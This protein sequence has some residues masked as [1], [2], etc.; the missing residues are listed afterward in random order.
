MMQECKERRSSENEEME[1]NHNKMLDKEMNMDE[2][3][4]EA[5]RNF[6]DIVKLNEDKNNLMRAKKLMR[7]KIKTVLCT[8]TMKLPYYCIFWL[9]TFIVT[10]ITESPKPKHSL[11]QKVT[12][13]MK[14]ILTIKK[15]ATTTNLV[16]K[17]WQG[18]NN[19]TRTNN[20]AR[21]PTIYNNDDF[22]NGNSDSA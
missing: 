1:G 22:T 12:I 11:V 13:I 21:G 9:Y 6:G 17:L 3:D 20:L 18:P 8:K 7:M 4:E 14:Q 5:E 2:E 10:I 15:L 16:K 19:L